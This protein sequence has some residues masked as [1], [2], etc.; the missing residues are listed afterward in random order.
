MDSLFEEEVL[1]PKLSLMDFPNVSEKDS[2]VP[3]LTLSEEPLDELMEADWD[4][5]CPRLSDCPIE[6][7]S[8]EEA[9][10]EVE[11]DSDVPDD[12]EYP[13]LEPSVV[14]ALQPAPFESFWF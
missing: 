10:C 6:P 1:V 8:P 5:D 13:T 3:R 12:C 9:E 7:L 14:P 4:A 11:M 2:L